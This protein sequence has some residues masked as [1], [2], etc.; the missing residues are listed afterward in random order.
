MLELRRNV[1]VPRKSGCKTVI[2][3]IIAANPS[4][5]TPLA[6]KHS[7]MPVETIGPVKSS[8]TL[9]NG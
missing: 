3:N 9:Y 4:R 1:I 8:F 6:T 7:M 2:I 5:G